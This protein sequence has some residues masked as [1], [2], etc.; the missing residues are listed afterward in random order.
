MYGRLNF[1]NVSSEMNISS[2]LWCVARRWL[3]PAQGSTWPWTRGWWVRFRDWTWA[4]PVC[5]CGSAPSPGPSPS[6][7]DSERAPRR[8]P[9]R[10]RRRTSETRAFCSLG[11]MQEPLVRTFVLQALQSLKSCDL[12]ELAAFANLRLEPRFS[13]QM[14]S[15]TFFG[16]LK[17]KKEKKGPP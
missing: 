2:V 7:R 11:L 9:S 17:R 15:E 16:G 1:R 4:R 12:R 8:G 14:F 3:C 13:P 10:V 5:P 6:H